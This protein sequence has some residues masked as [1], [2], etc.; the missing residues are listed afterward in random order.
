MVS[1]YK[2]VVKYQSI[3]DIFLIDMVEK[4]CENINVLHIFSLYTM[5]F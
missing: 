3:F 2:M 4:V 1:F 5:L